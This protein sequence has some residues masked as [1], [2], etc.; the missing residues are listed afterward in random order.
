[1]GASACS[2]P[3]VVQELVIASKDLIRDRATQYKQ[4]GANNG[5][6]PQDHKPEY[7]ITSL[8][9]H[10]NFELMNNTK[11]DL[12]H[13]EDGVYCQRMAYRY[14]ISSHASQELN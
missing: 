10:C 12:K 2:K 6:I 8:K 13:G 7:D 1:M 11:E 14:S 3:F 9:K 5:G 4:K